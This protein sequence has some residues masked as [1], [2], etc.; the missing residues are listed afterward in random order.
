MR[1][2]VLEVRADSRTGQR[3]RETRE[4]RR[5]VADEQGQQLEREDVALLKGT[6][7][8]SDTRLAPDEKRTETFSFQVPAGTMTDVKAT[9]W[10]YF[11]PRAEARQR[12]MFLRIQRLVK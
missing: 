4:Y 12:V 2:V 10:Y 7:V 1:H 8:I 5:R 9:F 3:F 11:S 6:K